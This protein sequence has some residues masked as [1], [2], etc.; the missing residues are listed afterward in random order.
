MKYLLHLSISLLLFAAPFTAS[1][2][3]IN[4]TTPHFSGSGNCTSC[5][6]GLT[7]TAGDNVSIVRDW[8]ASMMANSS[9]DPLWQAKVA[10]ELKRNPQLSTVINDTCT[11]C[12][13]PMANYE[14]TRVQGGEVTLL[15][16]NGILDSNHALYDAGMDGVSCTLC[17]QITDD[18][19]LGSLDGFSGRY[20]IN[21]T[22]TI[23]GQFSDIFGNPMVMNTGYTPTYSAH[24]SDSALCATCH[25]LKTPF[26]DGQGNVLTTSP[27]SE[28][29][30]QMPYTEWQNSI[31][32]D[33]GSNPQSCQDCHMPTTTSKV[34]NR[35]NWLAPK[36]GFAKH[37]LV[38]ANTTMLTMLRD[39]AAQLGVTSTNMD[40]GID[41]ARAMLQSAATVEIVSAAVS[42]GML[43]VRV[44]VQNQSGHKAP[45]AYPSRRIWLHFKVTDSSSNVIFESGRIDADGSIAGADNDLDQSVFE[46]HYE[47]I[48]TAD[49][50]Q[51]YET[52]M[53]DSNGNITFTL[54]RAAQYLKDNRLT[55]QG[56]DKLA[57]PTDVEVRGLAATDADF[58][59]GSDEI[60]YRFPVAVAGD[61]DVS[62]SLNYQTIAHGY[63]QDMYA[64]KDL[65]QVRTF[66]AMYDAQS[67]K[68]EQIAS[69]RTT[70]VN[71]SPVP[72]VAPV[73]TLSAGATVLDPGQS[74][75]LSW[76]TSDAA[77]CTAS[78]AWNGTR[79]TSGS[80]IVSPTATS[81]YTLNCDGAGGS[82]IDSVAITV[83]Q[84]PAS[85]PV[86]TLSADTLAIDQGQSAT[87]S[88]TSTDATTCSADWTASTA[89]SGS[90]TLSPAATTTYSMTCTGDGGSSADSMTVTVNAPPA[91]VAPTVS[92][93]ASPASVSRG[94]TIT[95]SW[96]STDATSC[97]AAGSWSGAKPVSGAESIVIRDPVTFALTCSGDGGTASSSVSYRARGRRWLQ[98]Q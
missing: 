49:Q 95:L 46:P 28:F 18:A 50:V 62:V 53:G 74:T 65:E 60:T 10:T 15:G 3:N 33:G 96:S 41:R 80:E 88:W 40:L 86:V 71:D 66:K 47:L 81:T 91:A 27:E 94:S 14:I 70:V 45:T 98:L 32:D 79:G 63:L 35:P 83:N 17:H 13:A 52:V 11:R 51:I 9:K 55:P 34:S 92:L 29:P 21:A 7:D 20:N 58:N 25:N 24:S 57:V 87:L 6:D 68:H 43:E 82:V 69:T 77:S 39:N 61:L 97:T 31:F 16:P 90:E 22:K 78:G 54:L 93:T 44:R 23:Y 26:V 75:T 48:T 42:D 19:T 2:E 64:D 72:P 59:L 4:F 1:S 5:H 84:P 12:H 38:G 30:E 76:T 85:A 36:S 8:G 73:L 37:H 56:F 67:L 89:T